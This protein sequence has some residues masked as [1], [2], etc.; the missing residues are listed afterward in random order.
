MLYI[1]VRCLLSVVRYRVWLFVVRCCSLC[2]VV[3][4]LLFALTLDS[5][6]ISKLMWLVVCDLSNVVCC[7]SLFV[8]LIVH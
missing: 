2:V 8:F 4:C 7:L 6:L 1:V 5:C 3:C